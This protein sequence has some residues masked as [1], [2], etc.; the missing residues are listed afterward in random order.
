MEFEFELDSRDVRE[1]NKLLN[2]LGSEAEKRGHN[3]ILDMTLDTQRKVIE[4][5]PV[6]TGRLQQSIDKKI[7]DLEGIIFTNVEY[8]PYVEERHCER[9]GIVHAMFGRT[10]KEQNPIFKRKLKALIEELK[11]L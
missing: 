3:F 4:K 2:K 9:H 10:F 6:D 8:A 7:S 5:T 11:K 1:F